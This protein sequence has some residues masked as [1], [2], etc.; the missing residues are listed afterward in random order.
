MDAKTLLS[1]AI[2][3]LN[4]WKI[5]EPEDLTVEPMIAILEH[6]SVNL[7]NRTEAYVRNAIFLAYGILGSS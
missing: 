4:E 5:E 2:E 7:D 1:S 3:K 6:A